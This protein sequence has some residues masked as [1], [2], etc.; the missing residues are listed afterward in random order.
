MKKYQ[1]SVLFFCLFFAEICWA[2]KSNDIY[3]GLT[4]FEQFRVYPYVDKAIRYENQSLFTDAI[5]ELKH[6]INISPLHIPFLDYYYRLAIK[7]HASGQ[8]LEKIIALYPEGER[9]RVQFQYVMEKAATGVDVT[10]HQLSIWVADLSDQQ[11]DAVILTNAYALEKKYSKQ[12]ALSWISAMNEKVSGDEIHRYEAYSYF[13]SADYINA[14]RQLDLLKESLNSQDVITK[15]R[16]LLYLDKFDDFKLLLDD[17][18]IKDTQTVIELKREYVERLIAKKE[19]ELAKYELQNLKRDTELTEK[20]QSQLTYLSGQDAMIRPL[21]VDDCLSSVNYLMNNGNR[22]EAQK[23][24]NHC[25]AVFNPQLWMYYAVQLERYNLLETVHFSGKDEE[26]RTNLLIDYYHSNQQWENLSVLLEQPGKAQ[27]RESLLATAYEKIGDKVKSAEIWME[28][29]RHEVDLAYLDKATFILGQEKRP[30]LLKIYFDEAREIIGEK[31]YQNNNL[32][33]RLYSLVNNH[34][35][36]FTVKDVE[37]L[38]RYLSDSMKIS[39]YRWY[40][41]DLCD[42]LV[43]EEQTSFEKQVFSVCLYNS[44][45]EK[46]A[47]MYRSS[48]SNRPTINELNILTRWYAEQNNE[49]AF[50]YWDQ[51][52]INN[53]QEVTIDQ[54]TRFMIEMDKYQQAKQII[55]SYPHSLSQ[56]WEEWRWQVQ[57][58][59]GQKELAYENAKKTLERYDSAQSVIWVW[60]YEEN[61]HYSHETWLSEMLHNSFQPLSTAQLAYHLI[62]VNAEVAEILFNKGITYDEYANDAN[63]LATYADLVKNSGNLLFAKE[64]YEASIDLAVMQQQ[65][66]NLIRY[67]QDSHRD[68]NLGWKFSLE[69]WLGHN[70]GINNAGSSTTSSDYFVH[71]EVKYYF[72]EPL[73]PRTDFYIGGLHSQVFDADTGNYVLNEL[74][75]GYEFQIAKDWNYYL[76]FGVKQALGSDS[77]TNY[78]ARFSADIFSNDNWSLAWKMNQDRWLYHLLYLDAVQY[79][80]DSDDY[81]LYGRYSIGE[82]FKIKDKNRHRLTPYLFSQW[83]QTKGQSEDIRTGTG[84]TWRWEQGNDRYN[85]YSVISELGVEWQHTLAKAS[86]STQSD[87]LLLRF[88]LYY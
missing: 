36:L 21:V 66:I 73:I 80:G 88:A 43:S 55:D 63:F 86:S 34:L 61:N 23:R 56:Q 59:T 64:L 38:N 20:E 30:E 65:D 69:G 11:A 6:A 22:Y 40:A 54:I 82:T 87:A 29:F 53:A 17:S 48:L 81:S 70:S 85:G 18:C 45:P 46:A 79:Y 58:K 16:S 60:D 37:L 33:G 4:S 9:A 52:N 67:L 2:Q 14:L 44:E 19:F 5:E 13:S 24:L 57:A 72:S 31:V 35:S 15:A 71:E 49:L 27:G 77:D 3:D 62:D 76:K 68:L 25:R 47:E 84:L 8:D 83:S 50:I 41:D 32:K 39:S 75:L 7:N 1:Y 28:L 51:L 74:D 12:A 78:Y 10:F 26:K 42:Q